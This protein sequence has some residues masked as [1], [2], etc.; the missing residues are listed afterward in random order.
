MKTKGCNYIIMDDGTKYYAWGRVIGLGPDSNDIFYGFDG[1]VEGQFDEYLGD[2]GKIPKAH[3]IEI[4]DFMISLWTRLKNE[5][6]A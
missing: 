1:R 2:Y 6:N 4:A 3:L 5:T